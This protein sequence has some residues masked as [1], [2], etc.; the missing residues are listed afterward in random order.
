M[1]RIMVLGCCGAGKS[2]F[3]KKLHEKTGLELIHLDQY[4]WKP[5]WIETETKE[6]ESIVNDLAAKSNWII[7][8]NYGGTMD[9]RIERADTIIFLN[10][11][12][13]TCLYRV[14]SRIIKNYGRTRSDMTD[15][16]P[17]RFD[18]QFLHYVATF[19][20]VRRKGILAK[21]GHVAKEKNCIVL[22]NDK[23]ADAFLGAIHNSR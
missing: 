15:G 6:W 8:G 16:C 11:S 22:R 20:I 2:T 14:C 9:V 10:Y 5:N 18:Y 21:M 7:D 17:E 13:A 4:Y 3:S 23:E 12:T 19:N 1:E